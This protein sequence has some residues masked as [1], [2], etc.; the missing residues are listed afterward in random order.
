MTSPWNTNEVN[1]TSCRTCFDERL[2]LSTSKKHLCRP[3]HP[4]AGMYRM[5][6]SNK[7]RDRPDYIRFPLAKWTAYNRCAAIESF[8]V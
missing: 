1:Y 4:C 6:L 7:K 8:F 3:S 5:T 2:R